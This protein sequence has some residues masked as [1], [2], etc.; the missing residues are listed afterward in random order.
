MKYKENSGKAR[1]NNNNNKKI[2]EKSEK[3]RKERKVGE[4]FRILVPVI[5]KM[6]F[7]IFVVEEE[8]LDI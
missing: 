1:Q 4:S 8:G 5:Q 7:G 3:K 2:E 6:R